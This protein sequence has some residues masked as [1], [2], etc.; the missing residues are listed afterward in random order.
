MSTWGFKEF[1]IV[2]HK[3]HLHYGYNHGWLQSSPDWLK[4]GITAVWNRVSCCLFG[5]DTY[6]YDH[7]KVCTACCKEW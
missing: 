5:H 4:H 1:G 2:L 7:R 6:T 3:H